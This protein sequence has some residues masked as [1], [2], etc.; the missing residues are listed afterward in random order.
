M[1]Q[2]LMMGT[3]QPS[4]IE[5]SCIIC[6]Y[7]YFFESLEFKFVKKKKKKILQNHPFKLKRINN[8]TLKSSFIALSLMQQLMLIIFLLIKLKLNWI[9]TFE[10]YIC[11]ISIKKEKIKQK[12]VYSKKIRQTIQRKSNVQISLA[13]GIN[14]CNNFHCIAIT[15]YFEVILQQHKWKKK[16]KKNRTEIW[17]K[18]KSTSFW[19]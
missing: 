2:T 11:I 8:D 10:I 4:L 7:I 12:L 13:I 1:I 9:N 15:S 16:K 14:I 6:L 5:Q 18:M 17:I 19:F 3:I